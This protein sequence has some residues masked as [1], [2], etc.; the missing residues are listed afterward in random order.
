M[1]QNFIIT[2]RETLEAALIIGIILSYLARIKQTKY[3]N[4]IYIGVAAGIIASII[5]ALI[6][7]EIAG[8]F[9]GR[10]EQI[11]EGV[12]M[13]IGAALLTTMIF[14]MMKQKHIASELEHKVST[15]LNEAHKFGLFLLVFVAVLREGIETVIFLGAASFVSTGNSLTG[16]LAGIAAAVL[17][18]YAIFV[19]SMKIDLKKFFNIT[20][21]LLILF[22]AGLVAHGIHEFE[23][24]GI[25]PIVVEHVWD[26]NS[27]L[28]ENGLVGSM[29]KGLFGYNGNPSLIEVLSYI[30]YVISVLIFWKNIERVHK[31][32]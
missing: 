30:I 26:I 8:G 11:F 15:E 9:T 2:F 1:L 17:L 21:V 3:N 19:G 23:E 18:G 25:I 29:L 14:W 10:A 13:L 31:V 7:T 4:V 5:G 16:S 27:I 32:I 6:F 28:N 24:A 12:T 20:S 22:A